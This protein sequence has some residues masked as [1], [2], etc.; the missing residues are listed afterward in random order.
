MI[1]NLHT[2]NLVGIPS[3]NKV[4][5]DK[6]NY[7][8]VLYPAEVVVGQ[9]P[10]EHGRY[11]CSQGFGEQMLLRGEWSAIIWDGFNWL[12]SHGGSL[13]KGLGLLKSCDSVFW[14]LL[15]LVCCWLVMAFTFLWFYLL[16]KSFAVAGIWFG[17]WGFVG[18]VDFSRLGGAP[19]NIIH[20]VHS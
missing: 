12:V 13:F 10:F 6:L 15:K 16:L 11:V 3:P 8:I 2:I 18:W 19:E 20:F 17:C 4:L 5:F 9:K 1:P 14:V 7:K